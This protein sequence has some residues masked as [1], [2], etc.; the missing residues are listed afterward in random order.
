MLHSSSIVNAYQL[1][2]NK[3]FHFIS[4]KH[5]MYTL[6]VNSLTSNGYLSLKYT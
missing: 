3:Q 6:R 5:T 4:E 1:L 2:L